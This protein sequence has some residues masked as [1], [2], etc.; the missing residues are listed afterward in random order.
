M[1]ITT[2]RFSARGVSWSRISERDSSAAA[3]RSP[4]ASLPPQEVKT[5]STIA[6]VRIAHNFLHKLVGDKSRTAPFYL[7]PGL[8]GK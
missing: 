3:R 2:L 8:A 5:T 4:V 6:G 1:I 7:L